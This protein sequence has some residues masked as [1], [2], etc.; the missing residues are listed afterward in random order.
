M[1]AFA[2]LALVGTCGRFCFVALAGFV[3]IVGIVGACGRLWAPVFGALLLGLVGA[4]FGGLV[5]ALF[6]GRVAGWACSS[7]VVLRRAFRGLVGASGHMRALSWFASMWAHV[8]ACLW[9]EVALAWRARER[10]WALA[11]GCDECL[12]ALVS[13]WACGRLWAP[14]SLG[15]S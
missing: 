11:G 14:V 9:A 1:G 15:G 5:G 7:W 6:V 8:G 13:A 4:R 10:M 2:G 3:G 12:W